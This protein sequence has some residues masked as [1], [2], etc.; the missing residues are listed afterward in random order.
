MTRF[1]LRACGVAAAALLVSGHV[2]SPN[3]FFEGE[4]G[5]YPVRVVVRPPE[6]IPGLADITV[7]APAGATRVTVQPVRWDL[8]SE[9]APRPDEA[10]PVPGD[11]GLWSANLW[12]MEFGSY[13]VHVAVDGPEGTGRVIV[14]VPAAATQVK[15]MGAGLAAAL[16]GLGLFLAVGLLTIVGAAVREAVLPP[17]QSPD[18]RRRRRAWIARALAVP[19]LGAVLWLGD[20]WWDSEDA[21]Y[22]ANLYQ[23]PEIETSVAHGENGRVLELTITEPTWARWTPLLPDHGKLMHMFLVR[24]DL[25]AFAHVHPVRTD[26]VT[27]TLPLP[28]LPAG[29]YAL[30][31]DVVHESGF[32]QTL[33]D[34]VEVPAGAGEPAPLDP[35]DSWHLAAASAARTVTLA[36]GSRMHW[37]LADS[38]LRAGR[39]TTLT[40]HVTDAEGAPVRLQP[41]MG[42]MSHAAVSR[43]DGAVF[44]HL[45]PMG[46]ASMTAQLLF[47]QRERGDTARTRSGELVL[48]APESGHAGHVGT[49]SFPYEFPRP[50]DY[51]IWVQV[52]RDDTVLTGA[53]RTHVR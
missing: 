15:E 20:N 7:R 25:A 13:S 33:V 1:L 27:F 32:P 5:P 11:A 50:G 14:P 18:P 35:D 4:A 41:Y 6:V 53:F 49:V 47:E 46:S 34:A 52:K 24:D 2:G 10:R 48:A 19:V 28:P 12:F 8:G 45:H 31:A 17:G 9:G 39:E 16:A 37:D 44:V 36:D 42:M 38:G 23:A 30:Y 22:A 3:V 29:R 43:V 21:A 40:F 26:S 51:V